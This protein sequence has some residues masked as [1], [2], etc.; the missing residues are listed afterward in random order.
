M[1]INFNLDKT[2]IFAVK[3]DEVVGYINIIIPDDYSTDRNL[4][5]GYIYVDPNFRRNNIAT[6][7]LNFL[8]NNMKDVVWISLWTSRQCEM[9]RSFKLYHNV[10]F[11]EKIYLED[12]YEDGIG[13]RYF[14]KKIK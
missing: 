8:I 2:Q 13:T 5:I 14:T 4:E 7:M 9:D 11:Q 10:G 6:Q 1:T 12:Y 3:N